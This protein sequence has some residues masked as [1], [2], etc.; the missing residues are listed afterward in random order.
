[1]TDLRIGRIPFDFATIDRLDVS[2]DRLSLSGSVTRF[3]DPLSASAA[4]NALAAYASSPDEPFIP[5]VWSDARADVTGYYRV[6]SAAV[7]GRSGLAPC[8]GVWGLSMELERVRGFSAPLFE[9]RT[10]GGPR[11]D[12]P[13]TVHYWHALPDAATG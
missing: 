13:G 8:G 12:M 1:M 5:V 4:A 6:S 11:E 9:L 10:L 2:D 7:E 3:D